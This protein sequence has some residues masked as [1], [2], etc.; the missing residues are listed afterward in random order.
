MQEPTNFMSSDEVGFL[1]EQS[2]AVAVQRAAPSSVEEQLV[3]I[4]VIFCTEEA[5][6]K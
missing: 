4:F 3:A 6:F 1:R 5:E 2:S